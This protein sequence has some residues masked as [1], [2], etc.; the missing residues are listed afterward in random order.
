MRKAK[1]L[2]A[3]TDAGNAEFF[4]QI[5]RDDLRYDHRRRRWMVWRGHWWAEDTDGQAQSWAKNTARMRAEGALRITDEDERA[6]QMAW[7]LKS[8]SHSKLE[9]MLRLA[10]SER[11]L[12]DSGTEW[13]SDPWLLG[14]ANGVIDLRTGILQEGRPGDRITLRSQINFDPLAQAPR[15]IQFLGE[16][17]GGDESM[18]DYVQRA[19]GYSLTGDTREQC[20]FV[21]YGAGANG[22]S[23]FVDTL[24]FVLGGYGYNLPFS[25]LELKAK[26]SIPNDV[27]AIV[28]RRFITSI[29]TNE[30]AALNEAR[31]KALTGGDPITARFLYSEFFTFIPVA[32]FW[33]AVNHLPAIG[34]DSHGFWRRPRVIPFLQKFAGDSLDPQ[35]AEK[36]RAEAAGILAWAVRGCL[37]WQKDGLGIP[38]TVRMATDEYRTENDPLDDFLTERC[39]LHPSAHIV[40]AALWEEYQL[41]AA[42]NAERPLDR[43]AFTCRLQS[44][45]LRKLRQGHDRTWTW[46][47]ICREHDAAGQH[48]PLPVQPERADADV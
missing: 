31:I 22:K 29:E 4:A 48:I 7:A 36:L 32:K 47:G 3:C 1:K 28:G 23:T 26:A 38:Q 44:R 30:G 10:Q 33:L 20:L 2:P 11:P 13:D 16:I 15:W 37:K 8:E 5:N 6:K 18:I 35:L 34:D 40:A 45:G 14:V 17:F 9:A 19:I 41:W 12:A 24:L 43:R 39:V 46:I 21:D 42:D 25:A 27:A